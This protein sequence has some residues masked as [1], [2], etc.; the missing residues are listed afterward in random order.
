MLFITKKWLA[1]SISCL[2]L[3]IFSLFENQG[4]WFHNVSEAA[5]FQDDPDYYPLQ[6]GNEWEFE[7]HFYGKQI[8]TPQRSRI[9]ITSKVDIGYGNIL[10]KVQDDKKFLIKNKEG[11]VT[12][13]GFYLLKYPL[14]LGEEWVFAGSPHVGPMLFRIENMGFSINI[15]GKTYKNCLR[16][17]IKT[18]LRKLMFRDQLPEVTYES[19]YVYAPNVGPVLVESFEVMK[20]GEKRLVS[21]KE[22]ITFK[23]KQPVTKES[24]PPTKPE[25]LVDKM[26]AFKFP[27]RGF[28]GPLLSPDEK[29]LIY[30]KDFEQTIYYT[31]RERSD[32]KIVPL[33]PKNEKYKIES[34]G[35]YRKWSP[36]GKT[37]A[38]TVGIS[39]ATRLVLVDFS[40]KKP[41]CIESFEMQNG[42]FAWIQKNLLVY[43]DNFG[44][45]MKKS[46]G[47]KPERVVFFRSSY[48]GRI[49]TAYELQVASNGTLVYRI[50]RSGKE[51]T[52]NND[53]FLTNLETPHSRT[54]IFSGIHVLGMNLSPNGR[55]VL[56]SFRHWNT[57]GKEEG[58]ETLID[59]SDKKDMLTLPLLKRAIWS[60]DGTKLAF[61]EKKHAQKDTHDPSKTKWT[62]P[63]FFTLDLTTGQKRDY[64]LGW[65]DF[66]WT[67]DGNH[68]IYSMKYAHESRT[69]YKMGVFIMR[70]SDGKEIGQLTKVSANPA[71]VMSGSGKYIVWEAL[72]GSTFFIAEN[73]FQS[74]MNIESQ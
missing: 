31:K 69:E 74:E 21:R 50:K 67:P 62:N 27:Q 20:S 52:W 17:I 10:Y 42:Q 63:H 54:L 25:K 15:K 72:S 37:L 3:V 71:P 7:Q 11:I 61:L 14:T 12:P 57:D 28:G 26:V 49:Q 45:I 23:T 29:W 36:D 9:I 66:N 53:I 5:H 6:I 38:F 56:V 35:T 70:V 43:I 39:P 8:K 55:Y 51:R 48:S 33:F 64:G 68:I 24:S 65:R 60:P 16:V 34:V 47:K 19:Q 2:V 41:H 4:I 30:R 32:Q 1:I 59:L 40:G 73:P 44:N 58:K 46:P 22:L 18:D 13:M